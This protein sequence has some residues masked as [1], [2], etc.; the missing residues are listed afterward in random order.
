M[1]TFT[2]NQI[3]FTIGTTNFESDSL[4]SWARGGLGKVVLTEK[5]IELLY[6]VAYKL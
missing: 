1:D 5:V 3:T 2:S 6:I 4:Q